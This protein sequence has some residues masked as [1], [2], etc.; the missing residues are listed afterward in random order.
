[1]PIAMASSASL[2]PGFLRFF[3][4]PSVGCTFFVSRLAAFPGDLTLFLRIHDGE[5]ASCLGHDASLDP[6]EQQ[7]VVLRFARYG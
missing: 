7:S 5:A 1:M 6:L 3:F 4:R 2:T